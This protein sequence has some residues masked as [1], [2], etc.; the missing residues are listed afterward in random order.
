MHDTLG[1]VFNTTMEA[2]G[3]E[4]FGSKAA[5]NTDYGPGWIISINLCLVGETSG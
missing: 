2:G 5:F 3:R 1:S 4:S